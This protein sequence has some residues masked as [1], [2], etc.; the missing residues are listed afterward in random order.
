MF[1]FMVF[2][3]SHWLDLIK[4]S[5][6]LVSEKMRLAGVPIDT[7]AVPEKSRYPI[8]EKPTGSLY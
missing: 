6:M 7:V 5:V 2:V 1:G 8:V 4:L 3:L